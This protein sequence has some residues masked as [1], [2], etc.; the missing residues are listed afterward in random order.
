VAGWLLLEVVVESDGEGGVV[1][2]LELVAAG[3]SLPSIGALAAVGEPLMVAGAGGISVV[4]AEQVLLAD[5]G[6]VL[7][8]V[9]DTVGEVLLLLV[10]QV[11]DEDVEDD[12]DVAGTDAAS[13]TDM[14]DDAATA[15]DGDG[16][17]DDDDDD[18]VVVLVVASCCV[19]DAER[20]G[21]DD[22]EV[23]FDGLCDAV[24][25]R[26]AGEATLRF[27]RSLNERSQSLPPIRR[28]RNIACASE[29]SPAR[30]WPAMAIAVVMIKLLVSSGSAAHS[31]I[32]SS[33]S[34]LLSVRLRPTFLVGEPCRKRETHRVS[35][36]RGT[37]Q[38]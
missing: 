14:A 38:S 35:V 30:T 32:N 3:A 4:E 12:A 25:G 8:D 20:D 22:D 24:L 16:D 31:R 34:S 36:V 9:D 21:D 17:D 1:L 18:V 37:S 6:A 28:T 5:S 7:A 27:D 15:D 33:S 23:L 13:S 29:F 10:V 26:L 19:G 2:Q 11:G